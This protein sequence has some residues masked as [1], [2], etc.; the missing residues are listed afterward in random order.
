MGGVI[1]RRRFTPPQWGSFRGQG[2]RATFERKRKR[3]PRCFC[4]GH[5]EAAGIRLA[6]HHGPIQRRLFSRHFK[7]MVAILA[8]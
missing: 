8:L 1:L 5:T 6:G 7:A 2:K 3:H 4:T